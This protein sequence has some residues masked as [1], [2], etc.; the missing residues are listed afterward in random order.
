MAHGSPNLPISP[1]HNFP[2]YGIMHLSFKVEFNI[3]AMV[4]C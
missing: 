1:C 3:I 2:A 4:L